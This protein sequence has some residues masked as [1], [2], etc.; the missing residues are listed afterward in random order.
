MNGPY[1]RHKYSARKWIKSIVTS[2]RDESCFDLPQTKLFFIHLDLINI[3]ICHNYILLFKKDKIVSNMDINNWLSLPWY[4]HFN[5]K[6]LSIFCIISKHFYCVTCYRV[7]LTYW[8]HIF[9]VCLLS[10]SHKTCSD[11]VTKLVQTTQYY[12]CIYF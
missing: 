1:E 5:I 10:V 8:A 3:D 7:V 9:I 2:F 11:S 4:D 12:W 6:S